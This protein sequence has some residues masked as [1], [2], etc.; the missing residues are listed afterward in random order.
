VSSFL[1]SSRL[2]FNDSRALL[3]SELEQIFREARV[4]PTTLAHAR[5]LEAYA[6]ATG[7]VVEQPTDSIGKKRMPS[8]EDDCPVCYD[9]MHGAPESSLVF[10][11]E[12]G[13]ALHNE[14]FAECM[15]LSTFAL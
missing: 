14:C 9:G 1:I 3:T 8:E 15:S 10:C 13:N 6:H 5:V 2:L 11:E 4:A 7:K 12:C